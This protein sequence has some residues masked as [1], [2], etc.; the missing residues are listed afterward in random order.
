MPKS[1]DTTPA[2]DHFPLW[3]AMQIVEHDHLGDHLDGTVAA[4][5]SDQ[6]WVIIIEHDVAVQVFTVSI[7]DEHAVDHIPFY[8]TDSG[9]LIDQN[10]AI[11]KHLQAALGRALAAG[12]AREAKRLQEGA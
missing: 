8:G 7:G 10:R 5:W 6:C 3:R 11:A 1:S 4:F 12:D 2:N 9:S